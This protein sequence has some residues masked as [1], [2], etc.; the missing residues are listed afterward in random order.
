M[1][2]QEMKDLRERARLTQAQM[3]ARMGLGKTAYVD[4]ELGDDDW[5]KFKHRHQLA[6]ERAS[7]SLAVERGDISLALSSARRDALALTRLITDSAPSP[8]GFTRWLFAQADRDDPVGDL[9]RDAKADPD[10]PDGTPGDCLDY[11]SQ[12]RFSA[13]R[14]ALMEAL[15]EYL[16]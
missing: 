15:D 8:A 2:V 16:P 9:A 10:F 3:A 11:L 7:L 5:K 1:S 12:P 14:K 6:L 13:G 4:L